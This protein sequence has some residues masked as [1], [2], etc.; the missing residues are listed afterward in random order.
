MTTGRSGPSLVLYAETKKAADCAKG[1]R[2][3][4]SRLLAL[5]SIRAPATA[6]EGNG[7]AAFCHERDV[8]AGNRKRQLMRLEGN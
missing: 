5:G 6:L 2:P 1:N 8:V 3:L 7:D 4:V